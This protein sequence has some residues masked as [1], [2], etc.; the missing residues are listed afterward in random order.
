M[1]WGADFVLFAAI[2]GR[3]YRAEL[4]EGPYRQI[5]LSTGT[6]RLVYREPP[7]GGDEP[8]WESLTAPGATW[9]YE[10]AYRESEIHDGRRFPSP[11]ALSDASMRVRYPAAISKALEALRQAQL[12]AEIPESERV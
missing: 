12:R 5:N 1:E 7:P 11:Q 2:S 3:C 4:R 10:A 8:T 6:V 9:H